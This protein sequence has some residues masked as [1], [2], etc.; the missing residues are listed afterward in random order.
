[1]LVRFT[2]G[3]E[4]KKSLRLLLSLEG[5]NEASE[6]MWTNTSSVWTTKPALTHML[7]SSLIWWQS[8]RTRCILLSRIRWRYLGVFSVFHLPHNN[9]EW[10]SALFLTHNMA[11]MAI[12]QLILH[13]NYS[14]ALTVMFKRRKIGSYWACDKP[15]IHL[16]NFLQMLLCFFFFQ[17]LHISVN[18]RLHLRG[19]CVCAGAWQLQDTWSCVKNWNEMVWAFVYFCHTSLKSLCHSRPEWLS[20]KYV[21]L[22]SWLP[23]L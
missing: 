5:M 18:D 16:R 20:E 8:S 22:W 3:K 23:S 12:K 1:M 7:L 14:P 11:L 15:T 17:T 4:K 6:D 10:G 9:T 13:D 21:Y 19:E 2:N